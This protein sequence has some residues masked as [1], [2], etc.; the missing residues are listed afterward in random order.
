MLAQEKLTD[1]PVA[2]TSLAALDQ[3]SLGESEEEM[4]VP[5]SDNTICMCLYTF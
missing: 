1:E 4:I 2:S 5:T 3:G